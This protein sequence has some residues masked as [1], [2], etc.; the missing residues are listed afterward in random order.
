MDFSLTG[1]LVKISTLLAEKKIGIF[2]LFTFNIDYIL[3]K[4]ENE[5]H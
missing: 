3:V 2:A 1:I 5:M 4:E